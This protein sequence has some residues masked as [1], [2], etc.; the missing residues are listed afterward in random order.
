MPSKD[1]PPYAPCPLARRGRDRHARNFAGN[2]LLYPNS[3]NKPAGAD[4]SFAQGDAVRIV[5]GGRS[6]CALR[7]KCGVRAGT[8]RQERESKGGSSC[9]SPIP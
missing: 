1:S 4:L 2:S 6:P 3:H 5:S 7:L 8:G 9:P